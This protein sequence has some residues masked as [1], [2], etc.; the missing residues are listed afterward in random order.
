MGKE[1]N[2]KDVKKVKTVRTK[3]VEKSKKKEITDLEGRVIKKDKKIKVSLKDKLNEHFNKHKKIYIIILSVLILIS[4]ICLGYIGIRNLILSKKYGEYEKKMDDYGFS[5]VYNNQLP[6]SYEKVTKAEMVKMIISSIYNTDDI[7][8]RGFI[9]NGKYKN[10]EWVELAE[11]IGIIEEGYI[12][13]K[14][15]NEFPTYKEAII[16][17]LKARAELLDIPVNVKKESSY[18]NLYSFSQEEQKYINDATENGLLKNSKKKLKIDNEL[19]KGQ[20]NMLVIEFV[21]KYN[22]TIPEGETVV[23]KSE[24]KPKN[25][26]IYPYVL[27]SVPKEVYEYKGI[28]EGGVDY[29]SPLE[30]YKYKKSSYEQVDYRS[31]IYYNAILNIDYRTIDKDTFFKTTNEFLRYDYTDTI[32]SYVDYVKQNNII[33][34]GKAEVQFPIFYLDGLRYRA[35]IK[36]TFEIKNS[37]TDKNILLGDMSRENEVTYVNDKYEVYIDAPMGTTILSEALLLDMEPI[38][39]L[40]VNDKEASNKNEF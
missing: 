12:T 32:N 21:E 11:A 33:I 13:E 28:N 6:K 15:Y 10:N 7:S 2:K 3:K 34:E 8:D 27:Y 36:L 29:K 20:F 26:D 1:Q 23:V 35:R 16:I 25:S 38:I 22:T 24:S 9:S 37:N 5:L 39:D 30:T 18:K 19:F 14:N 31:E 4:V 40:M 17:Y